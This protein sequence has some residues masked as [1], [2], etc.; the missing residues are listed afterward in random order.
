MKTTKTL[1]HQY[2]LKQLPTA[3]ALVGMDTVLIS[4]SDSWH[5]IFDTESKLAKPIHTYYSGHENITQNQLKKNLFESQEKTLRH[6]KLADGKEQWFNSS[7]SPWFDED[8]N[9]LGFI[10]QT[11]EITNLVAQE[12]ELKRTT[13]HL[14]ATAEIAKI[15]SWEY[16]LVTE[17]LH[18][19]EETKKI[20]QVEPDYKPTISEGINFYKQGYSRNRISML[21][22]KILENGSSYHE[23]LIII[24]N[25]GEER[26]V[27][28]AGKAIRKNGEIIKIFGTFQD[29]HEQVM[30]DKKI[31]ES[32]QLLT[33]L[34]DNLPINVF[35]KDK[36]SRKILVN[37]AE[38]EYLGTTPDTLLGKTDFDLYDKAVAQ[39]SRD[40]DLE[41]M[42]TLEPMLARETINV[43]KDGSSTNFLTS[44]IPILDLNGK[45]NG[46]I[47]MSMDITHIKQKEEQL[48]NLINVTAIQNKKLINFAHIVSHN[49]RSHT[50][51]F[52]M[53]LDF[54]I[55]ETEEKEKQRI[56]KMLFHA[57][58]NLLDTL[59]NLNEVVDIS[60]N[61]NLDKKSLNLGENITKMQQNLSAFLEENQVE[62]EN[63]IPDDLMVLSV[64]AYLESILLNLVTNAV[65]YRHPDRTP[66]VELR[67]IKQEK[68]LLFS[69]TDNGL[70][71]DLER[72]GKKIF[73]MYKT[74]HNNKD[75]RGLGLY[76]IKNQIEAMDGSISVNS[77]VDKG[78]TFNV[79]FNE[80]IE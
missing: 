70:G 16:D 18:W 21:F 40:E 3:T 22:H 51:N 6:K 37:K 75:A 72:Y 31:R 60:T 48:H 46:L 47:G 17:E 7:C 23:K 55:R 4:A 56:M 35:V 59:E 32:E 1:H 74:F 13:S 9:Q 57:S 26:W 62:F 25:K 80:K 69:V 2:I 54:L 79:Y 52:S 20:H 71:I 39:I 8:E 28:A 64:P 68:H 24:T 49:L 53:L 44:K 78:T 50:A 38:C 29:I 27:A 36:D 12:E 42:R 67:A 66:K 61:V 10:I 11:K 34:I 58:D 19:C 76:I 45:S 14:K 43:R 65:K 73:G 77:E 15:G 30:A 5:A 63:F 41:V 33:T